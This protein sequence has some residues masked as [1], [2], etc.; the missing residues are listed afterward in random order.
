MLGVNK[1]NIL[2]T[3]ARSPA[4]LDLARQ[5]SS[6]GHQ[7]FVA[8]TYE[9]HVCRFSNAICKSFIVPSPRFNPQQYINKLVEITR[10][11][12]IDF[13]IPTCEEIIYISKNLEHFPDSCT[14]F[15]APFE[16]LNQLHNKWLFNQKLISF[17]FSAPYTKLITSYNDLHLLDRSKTYALKASYSR[18]SQNIY[19]ITPDTQ[20]PKGLVIEKNNP[21]IAQEWIEGEKYCTYSICIDGQ[22]FAHSIYPVRFAIDDSSC[23]NFQS[24][25][26]LGIFEWVEKFAKQE[27]FTGQIAFDFIEPENGKIYAIECNP[28]STSGLHLFHPHDRIDRAFFGENYYPILPPIGREKQ[29]ALG[30]LLYSWQNRSFFNHIGEF[31]TQI[32]KTKDVVFAFNDIMPFLAM[33]LVFGRYLYQKIKMGVRLPSIFTYDIDWNGN[34]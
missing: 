14:V 21:W 9:L 34:E 1:K 24:T 5:L 31:F 28:R 2:L 29:I 25:K 11:N 20:L 17:Q 7:V 10:N 13:L 23:I 12:H 3:G 6:A 16:T 30:M 15:C 4:T 26:H 22:I 18:A 8:E 32:F 33:P 27:K 19:K